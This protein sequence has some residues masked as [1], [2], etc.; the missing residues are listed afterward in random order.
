MRKILVRKNLN[1]GNIFSGKKFG[2]ILQDM[3]VIIG[4][5]PQNFG[6]KNLDTKI[7]AEK[8]R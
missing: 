6:G 2:D 8:F 5:S 1:F 4:E 7:L 3:G